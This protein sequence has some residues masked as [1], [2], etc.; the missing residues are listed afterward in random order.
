VK[1][2]L[3]ALIVLAAVPAPVADKAE[4]G[5]WDADTNGVPKLL[6]TKVVPLDLGIVYGWRLHLT[7]SKANV[8][9]K[10][11]LTLPATPQ[12]WG[13]NNAVR[14]SGD[15][16]AATFE[17]QMQLKDGWIAEFIRVADGDPEGKHK[18]EVFIE[19]QLAQTFEFETKTD[20]PFPHGE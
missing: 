15:K 19:G 5:V 11:V 20:A 17:R 2:F 3:L 7:G 4:F 18:L 12:T 13:Q 6:I 1:C 8:R 14:L 10:Q 16:R 9:V